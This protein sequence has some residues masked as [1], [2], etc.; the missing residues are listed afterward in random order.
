[1]GE[2]I[3]I[4]EARIRDQLDEMVHGTVEEALIET[5]LTGVGAPG[6]EYHRGAL[7]HAGEALTPIT[8]FPTA[9]GANSG[10]TT[11]WNASCARSGDERRSWGR[12]RTA[13]PG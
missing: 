11:R 5:Y 6:R 1:M 10:P 8:L 12:F 9:I 2:V 4:D 13:S 7:G 3:Q